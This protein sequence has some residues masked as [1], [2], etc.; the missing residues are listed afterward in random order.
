M[1]EVEQTP[2]MASAVQIGGVRLYKLARRGVTV[3]RS[4]RTVRVFALD[5]VAF[6]PGRRPAVRLSVACSAGTYIR[7]LCAD[8]GRALGVG[9]TMSALRRTRVGIY[10][11]QD[12]EDMETCG[13][14][15][16]VAEALADWPQGDASD[17]A[18]ADLAQGKAINLRSAAWTREPRECELALVGSADQGIVAVVERQSHT[19]RPK[20]VLRLR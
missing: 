17:P 5:V 15:R 3:A 2:P 7:T 14:L 10:T 9:G 12:A 1:G 16:S 8:I 11:L 18:L 4:S 19:A 13:T 20:K 6:E